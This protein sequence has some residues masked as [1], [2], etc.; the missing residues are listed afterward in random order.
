MI[1]GTRKR[2]MTTPGS[3]LEELVSEVEQPPTEQGPGC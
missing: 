2:R 3:P 1:A